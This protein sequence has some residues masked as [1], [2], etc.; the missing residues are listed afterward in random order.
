MTRG[1]A[2][3]TGARAERAIDNEVVKAATCS[4]ALK[5]T[6]LEGPEVGA[7]TVI[8]GCPSRTQ[9]R[10][11]TSVTCTAPQTHGED[12][13]ALELLRPDISIV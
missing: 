13:E 3:V 8:K 5:A 12:S 9:V 11:D 10:L 6:A 7:A 1:A 2:L 4:T